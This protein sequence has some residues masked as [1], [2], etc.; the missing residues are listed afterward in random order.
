MA[1]KHFMNPKSYLEEWRLNLD[2][3]EFSGGKLSIVTSIIE[4]REDLSCS[5]EALSRQRSPTAGEGGRG[6][7]AVAVVVVVMVAGFSRHLGQQA[8]AI[9][10]RWV[11]AR[12]CKALRGWPSYHREE[13]LSRQGSPRA[14]E[15][16]GGGP[17][18]A[19]GPAGR[20]HFGEVFILV[21]TTLRYGCNMTG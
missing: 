3:N 9:V 6:G 13:A 21:D 10:V 2:V 17:Q 7:V 20:G 4:S 14:G 15:G 5:E 1:T 12:G 18:S 8:E 19:L 16:G 11:R